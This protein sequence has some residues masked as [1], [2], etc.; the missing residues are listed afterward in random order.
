[1]AHIGK[2]A[3][4]HPGV[5]PNP[6]H[7]VYGITYAP[8]GAQSQ[9][10]LLNINKV[11]YLSPADI[12]AIQNLPTNE[13]RL[14]YIQDSAHRVWELIASLTAG[15]QTVVFEYT[16]STDI[17]LTSLGIFTDSTDT[18]TTCNVAI[19]HESGLVVYKHNADTIDGTETVCDL[20]G[21]KR[22][23]NG[24]SG[25]TLKGGLKYYVQYTQETDSNHTTFYPAYFSG[26]AGNY[27]VWYHGSVQNKQTV[28]MAN[29]NKYWGLLDDS[30]RIFG[31]N[32]GDFFIWNGSANVGMTVGNCYVRSNVGTGQGYVFRGVIGNPATHENVTSDDVE[33]LLAWPVKTEFIWYRNNYTSGNVTIKREY[34]YAKSQDTSGI[35]TVELNEY[36]DW[37]TPYTNM[38]LL[39]NDL[40]IHTE[41]LITKGSIYNNLMAGSICS[42]KNG[43]VVDSTFD[44][45]TTVTSDPENPTVGHIYTKYDEWNHYVFSVVYTSNGWK[46]VGESTSGNDIGYADFMNAGSFASLLTEVGKNS[47]FASE[48]Y[49]SYRIAA[50][51]RDDT[52]YPIQTGRKYYLEINGKEV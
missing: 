41:T 18:N 23:I 29:F 34:V 12:T 16:P 8:P 35:D 5:E 42:L 48:T 49:D 14:A 22:H 27:K 4:H 52:T 10:D 2:I 36:V 9:S 19:Y 20:Q 33:Q 1:M 51:L 17:S 40:K 13:E 6:N 7:D 24:I 47:D 45:N 26:T 38:T 50:S 46:K 44:P 3:C 32:T 21:K 25:V 11:I 30:S 28:N 39:L 15:T 37:K 31:M 43:Y